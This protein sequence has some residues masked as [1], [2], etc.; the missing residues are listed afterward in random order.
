MILAQAQNSKSIIISPRDRRFKDNDPAAEKTIKELTSRLN[1]QIR[2]STTSIGSLYVDIQ[3]KNPDLEES[4]RFIVR[5][6]FTTQIK[7]SFKIAQSNLRKFYDRNFQEKWIQNR[8]LHFWIDLPKETLY[9]EGGPKSITAVTELI[10]DYMSWTT[11]SISITLEVSCGYHDFI[12]GVNLETIKCILQ[13]AGKYV[14]I[15]YLTV[16]N[17]AINLSGNK[18]C[19][20]KAKESIVKF[21]DELKTTLAQMTFSVSSTQKKELLRQLP[22]N[23]FSTQGVSFAFVPTKDDRFTLEVVGDPKNITNVTDNISAI[24]NLYACTTIQCPYWVCK[25]LL[26]LEEFRLNF[27]K[28]FQHAIYDIFPLKECIE[29]TCQ[30]SLVAETVKKIGSVIEDLSRDCTFDTMIISDKILKVLEAKNEVELKSIE[31]STYSKIFFE[32]NIEKLSIIN[33]SV[34]YPDILCTIVGA[35]KQIEKAKNLIKKKQDFYN[36]FISLVL[37]VPNYL[38]PYLIGVKGKNLNDLITK[39][40]PSCTISFGKDEPDL[41]RCTVKGPEVEFNNLVTALKSKI[42]EY[43]ILYHKSILEF[44]PNI[45]SILIN[46]KNNIFTVFRNFGGLKSIIFPTLEI[47]DNKIT[48]IGK[49]EIALNCEKYLY[50]RINELSKS[51]TQ[52]ISI[53]EKIVPILKGFGDAILKAVSDDAGGDIHIQ[54]PKTISINEK[55]AILGPSVKVD[56]AMDILKQLASGTSPNYFIDQ[57]LVPHQH[58]AGLRTL[59][60]TI[61]ASS[62]VRVY[63]PSTI[64][65]DNI[66]TILIFGKLADVKKVKIS[67]SEKIKIL[68]DTIEKTIEIKGQYKKEFLKKRGDNPTLVQKLSTEHGNVRITLGDRIAGSENIQVLIKGYKD[69]VENLIAAINSLVLKLD[70][71]VDKSVTFTIEDLNTILKTGQ[72]LLRNIMNQFNVVLSISENYYTALRSNNLVGECTV[73]VKGMPQDV[74]KALSCLAKWVISTVV[75]PCPLPIQRSALNVRGKYFIS[76]VQDCMIDIDMG[77]TRTPPEDDC[78]VTGLKENV[79]KAVKWIEQLRDENYV[80]HIEAP[81]KYFTRLI[82]KKGTFI[83]KF[84]SDNNVRVLIPSNVNE[85]SYISICGKKDDCFIAAKKITELVK[86]WDATITKDFTF[87]TRAKFK[88]VGAD[89]GVIKKI[90]KDHNVVIRILPVSE[91]HENTRILQISGFPENIDK[92]ISFLE[93]EIHNILEDVEDQY[94]YTSHQEKNYEFDVTAF[95]SM[96][97][98]DS[99]TP[100]K[101]SFDKSK[102]KDLN[103]NFPDHASSTIVSS[104]NNGSVNNLITD[105]SQTNDVLSNDANHIIFNFNLFCVALFS[106]CSLLI[107]N[108]VATNF[109]TKDVVPKCG[110][111]NSWCS[112]VC[113]GDRTLRAI[114]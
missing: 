26:V 31:E 95:K 72:F 107:I 84:S 113:L 10:E 48:L 105:C 54:L 76:L 73:N 18:R 65:R 17:G 71:R 63:F 51:V 23:L 22:D 79:D 32:T 100:R 92:C 30:K 46:E 94:I 83:K 28:I 75:I 2:M 89:N 85:Q 70:S 11:N 13:D 88:L 86:T 53:S 106:F 56:I 43:E 35:S 91:K 81:E 99:K 61:I 34:H 67:I 36:S 12:R 38:H 108:F 37:D 82:G 57:M 42:S 90:A 7:K 114:Y 49:K 5:E 14:D 24:I 58:L 110:E 55:L 50:D 62:G 66:D 104:N 98:I 44:P 21:Y 80:H 77:Y 25:F 45:K 15:S 52:S 74:Q 27:G 47:S 78:V 112:G 3:T 9:I 39:N 16:E 102:A 33:S 40:G 6:A 29:L 69:D 96:V 97:Y 8:Y 59:I 111:P 103:A 64:G 4:A 101:S 93:N 68:K 109:I 60:F 20:L 19:V 1:I 41:D 87:D